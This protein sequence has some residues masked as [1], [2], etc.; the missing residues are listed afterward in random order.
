MYWNE[1]WTKLLWKIND[2]KK[3]SKRQNIIKINL[4]EGWSTGI[5]FNIIYEM[6]GSDSLEDQLNELE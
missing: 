1:S 2:R 5:R 4:I 6:E 3:L